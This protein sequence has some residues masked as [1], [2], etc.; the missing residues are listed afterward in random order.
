MKKV[1]D[2]LI[3]GGGLAGASLL[4]ALKQHA[5]DALL[6]DVKDLSMQNQTRFD[7]RSLALAPASVNI[8]NCLNIWPELSLNATAINTIHVSMK[9]AFGA[10]RLKS[11]GKKP[12]GFIVPMHDIGVAIHQ[13]L[14]VQT[15]FAPAEIVELDSEQTI[16]KISRQGE[17]IEIHARCIVVADGGQT[18]MREHLGLPITVKHFNQ[19]AI[20]AN[21]EISRSHEGIAYERFTST[22]PIAMLPLPDNMV[23]MVWCLPIEKAQSTALLDDNEFLKRLQAHFGYRLGRFKQAGKRAVFPLK[24]AVMPKFVKWPYVFI[25]NAAHTLHPVAGQGFNL[26]LRDA[27]MLVECFLKEGIN[28]TALAHYQSL[29]HADQQA[30]TQL[31][32]GLIQGFNMNYPGSTLLKGLGLIAVEQMGCFKSLIARHARGFGGVVPDLA[33]GIAL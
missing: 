3:I 32:Y 11:Q 26:A 17:L 23:S 1:V 12:L 20:T 13:N 27:A 30:I 18:F 9:G 29:R 31:T 2:I 25:G 16:L 15:Y 4:L 8:L 7:M 6:I 33:C 14:P 28:E 21:I 5:I 22:G 19:Q 10:A 24:H